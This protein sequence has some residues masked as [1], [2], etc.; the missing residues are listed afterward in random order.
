ML[1]MNEA[2]VCMLFAGD[3]ATNNNN[4]NDN[5]ND[6][7]WNIDNDGSQNWINGDIDDDIVATVPS[8]PMLRPIGVP[9][10]G[11]IPVIDDDT[12]D[13]DTKNEMEPQEGANDMIAVIASP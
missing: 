6:N 7:E 5:D 8:T 13:N 10:Y 4:N 9:R 2:F 12:H 1:M 11:P 3:I